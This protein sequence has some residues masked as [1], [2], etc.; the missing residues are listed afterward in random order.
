MN[1]IS[2]KNVI[3]ADEPAKQIFAEGRD[4]VRQKFSNSIVTILNKT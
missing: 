1:V 4:E 2:Q 3:L